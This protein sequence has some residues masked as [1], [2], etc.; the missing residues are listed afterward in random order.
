MG[1]NLFWDNSNI[2]IV[3]KGVAK[4]RDPGDASAF[5]IHFANLLDWVAYDRPID[6]AFLAGSV[7]PPKD[8]LWARLDSLGVEVA[9]Q[10][11]GQL[12]G[13]EIAVDEVIQLAMA[14]RILDVPPATMILLT[15][16][17]SGYNEG[18]GFVKQLERAV[19]HKWEIEVVS[20][21][22]GCNRRLRQFALDHG[23]YRSLEGAYDRVTY[24]SNKRCVLPVS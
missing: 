18:K 11:R 23:I 21:N 16:D 12:T 20:W 24:I 22:A 6:Y 9:V 3:G 5:R 17:G 13:S 4:A 14:N 2:W 19:A 8:D 1:L 10:E 15:G 7:P